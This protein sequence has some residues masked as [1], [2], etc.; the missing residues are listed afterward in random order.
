[1]NKK[2]LLINPCTG[3]AGAYFYYKVKIPPL[4]LA[5]IAAV[6]PANWDVELIDE[7]VEDFV[8]QEADLVGISAFTINI[9]RAYE[10]AEIYREKGIPVILGGVHASMLPEEALK[11]CDS[12][13]VGEAELIWPKVIRDFEGG[14][15]QRIYQGEFIALENLPRPKRSIFKGKP[16]N[17]GII[18]TSRGCPMDCNFCSVSTFS[19]KH[20][21]MRPV[22][23]VLDELELIRHKYVSI[24]DDNL[25]GYGE[26][27]KKRALELFKGMVQRKI[28]KIW[29]TQVSI[30][31]ADDEEILYY[32]SQSGCKGVLIGFESLSK[33]SLKEMNKYVNI[34]YGVDYYQEAVKRIHKYGILVDGQIIIG[35]DGD[36]PGVFC[37]TINFYQNAKVD[38]CAPTSIVPYPGTKLFKKLKAERRLI[39]NDFPRDWDKYYQGVNF[40]FNPQNL[41]KEQIYQGWNYLLKRV[42]SLK[43]RIQKCLKT[44]V[45][46]KSFLVGLVTYKINSVYI[47]DKLKNTYVKY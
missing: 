43:S 31:F 5:Y 23:D 39:Y 6:T 1:M 47:Y 13:V 26:T 4:G 36:H 15:L 46:T 3:T 32:A 35:N 44:I 29:G 16:Y 30:N 9:N 45:Y 20:Y 38:I 37:D 2:L 28:N 41:S 18:Q 22:Q 40:L 8:F 7:D 24:V 25:I 19:G 42:F 12:V 10:I 14:N 27:A 33:E 17:I 21:R 34:K 11:F